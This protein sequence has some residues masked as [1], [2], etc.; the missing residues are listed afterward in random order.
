MELRAWQGGFVEVFCF[1]DLEAS[2]YPP[3]GF[4]WRLYYIGMINSLTTGD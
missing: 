2:K 4:L 3:L 1:L